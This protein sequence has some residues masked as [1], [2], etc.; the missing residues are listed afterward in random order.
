MWRKNAFDRFTFPVAVFLKRLAA[1]LCVFSFGIFP[2]SLSAPGRLLSL[3]EFVD[4]DCAR[5][6]LAWRL[7]QTAAVVALVLLSAASQLAFLRWEP[8]SGATC[9]LPDAAGTQRFPDRQYL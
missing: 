9:C 5:P 4:R 7:A 3:N 8:G 6:T 2:L 1:P